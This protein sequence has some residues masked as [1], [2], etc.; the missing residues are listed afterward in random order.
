MPALEDR[1]ADLATRPPVAPTPVAEIQGRARRRVRRRRVVAGSAVVVVVAAAAVGIGAALTAD[2]P[3]Q[4]VAVGGGARPSTTVGPEGPLTSL[5][6]TLTLEPATGLEVAD[7]V[8]VTAFARPAAGP[9]TVAQCASEALTADPADVLSW[10]V[11]PQPTD[12]DPGPPSVLVHGSLATPEGVVACDDA[13]GRCVVLVALGDPIGSDVRWA[14]LDLD[15]TPPASDER[16]VVVDGDEGTVGDGDT[17]LVTVTGVATGEWLQVQQCRTDVHP[18]VADPPNARCDEDRSLST[19][20]VEGPETQLEVRAFH[21]IGPAGPSSDRWEPCEPCELVVRG[22][23]GVLARLP[24]VMEPTETPIRPQIVLEPAGPH[25]PGATVTVRATGLQ[26]GRSVD[27]GWC[28][29]VPPQGGG[30]PFCTGPGGAAVSVTAD[31]DGTAVIPDFVLPGV[32]AADQVGDDCVGT[33]GACT[34]GIA[35]AIAFGTLAAAP[36]TLTG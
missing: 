15:A 16:G 23:P 28:P 32:D 31:G 6:P 22:G 12:L 34:V 1:L 14:P 4:D 2:D 7:R 13:P 29:T 24:L 26:P 25:A 10:C 27:I 8:R 3:A 5:D 33:P 11:D 20:V 19:A 17:L 35:A 30:T 21:D 9:A 36:L 18:E